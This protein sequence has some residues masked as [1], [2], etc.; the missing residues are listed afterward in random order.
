MR[1]Y[2]TLETGYTSLL[3]KSEQA[4]IALNLERRQI[5]EQ[6]RL[7]DAPRLPERPVS[8]DRLRLTL[9]AALAG[10]GFGVGLTALIEYRNT[11]LRSHEDVVAA[12][13][14]PVLAVVPLMTSQREKRH[15]R[16]V[17][18]IGFA[19]ASV[20]LIGVVAA[21]WRLELLQRLLP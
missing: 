17:R 16:L 5:G 9:L 7:I 13:S 11:S 19:T 4:R 6:F 12:L 1:D 2:E 14:L 20:A 15:Q 10:L 3:Q 8:P 18:W 21:A